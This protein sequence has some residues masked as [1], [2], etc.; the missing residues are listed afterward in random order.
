MSTNYS[1]DEE[2]TTIAE[3]RKEEWSDEE[4]EGSINPSEA[5]AQEDDTSWSGGENETD[6]Q[7]A[8]AIFGRIYFGDTICFQL[9]YFF[10]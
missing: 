10:R 1:D 7:P 8:G 6:T 4:D 5:L 2:E 3:G 9:L